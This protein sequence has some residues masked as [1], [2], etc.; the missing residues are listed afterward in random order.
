MTP[1]P[2]SSSPPLIR[3]VV[4]LGASN[5]TMGFAA[6]V[7]TAR[8]GWGRDVEVFAAFGHGRS[9]GVSSCVVCR[10]LPS[11]VGSGLWRELESRPPA[12]T[13]GLITDVGN[14][15]L[16]GFSCEQ[17]LAWVAE[18]FDRL[19]RVTRDVVVTDLPLASIRRLSSLK[20]LFLRGILFPPCRL[21]LA[22]TIDGAERLSAG[23]A[24]MA[25]ERGARFVTPD[26]SWYG[27]DPI[28]IRATARARAWRTILGSPA[29]M[30]GGL[31]ATWEAAKLALLTPER[32][33]LF[34]VE[35]VKAQ[36]GVALRAGGKVWL[37]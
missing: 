8:A 19:H 30:R 1:N 23:L 28:H 17:I 34:G 16:Y 24:A 10:T 4:A 35:R 2:D 7:S 14:D 13:R 20:F 22:Q 27:F 32:R 18:S 11:I 5:L 12:P 31:G 36:A 6:A 26:P 21:S 3:R 9:Y 29:E 15:I 25:K 37:Y 33:W